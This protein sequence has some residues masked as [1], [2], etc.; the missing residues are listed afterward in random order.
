[1]AMTKG[2]RDMTLEAPVHRRCAEFALTVCPHLRGR[3]SEMRPF[4]TDHLVVASILAETVDAEFNV[5]LAG[6]RVVGSLKFAWPESRTRFLTGPK[7]LA[8]I[9]PESAA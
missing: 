7:P 1:M 8:K 2:E 3:Q 4:P 6:R 5:H 9:Q